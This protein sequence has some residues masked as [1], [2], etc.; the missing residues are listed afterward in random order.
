MDTA[1]LLIRLAIGLLLAAHGLQKLA[2]WFGGYGL[3]GTGG[4]LEGFGFRHGRFWAAVAGSSEFFGGALFALGLLTP[5]AGA[6]I[7]GTMLVAART[8]HK[9]KGP[10]IFNGGWEYVLVNA[11]VTSA[12]GIAGPGEF[13]L[14]HVLDVAPHGSEWGWAAAAGAI[15]VAVATLGWRRAGVGAAASSSVSSSVSSSAA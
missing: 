1:L 12:V 11:V 2:G 6:A 4:Y 13:S 9:G 3:A 15:V 10:W 5:L 8:D 7:A 14:D